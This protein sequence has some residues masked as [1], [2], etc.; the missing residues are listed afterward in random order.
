MEL[1]FLRQIEEYRKF[2][3][4]L[5]GKKGP[6]RLSG[7]IEAAKPY[8]LALLARDHPGPVVFIRSSTSVLFPFEQ[9][10]RF[11]A[12]M[13]ASSSSPAFPPQ[14]VLSLPPLMDAPYQEIPPSLK[15]VSARMRFFYS[16]LHT[17]PSLVIT[18]LQ[19]LLKPFP[20]R[21]NVP[22]LFITLALG[23]AAG[24]D[25]FLER[26]AEFGYMREDLV[27]AHGEYAWRGGIVDIFSPWAEFPCRIEFRGDEI[28]S[29][30]EFDPTSQRS[31]RKIDRLVI[32]SLHEFPASTDFFDEWEEQALQKAPGVFLR[33]IEQKVA[34]LKAGDIFPSFAYAAL[35]NTRHFAPFPQD[36]EEALFVVDDFDEVA[37][38]WENSREDFQRQFADLESQ[39]I[40]ALP[41]GEIFAPD[42]W[43]RIKTEAV[44]LNPL[45]AQPGD[46]GPSFHLPF[47]AVPRFNNKIPFFMDYLK[48]RREEGER[49][50]I[51]MSGEGVRRK[52]AV[53]LKQEG[54]P[55]D[56]TNAAPDAKTERG[57]KLTTAYEWT[58]GSAG[59]E[60][61]GGPGEGVL[62]EALS[63]AA[64]SSRQDAFPV[65]NTVQ[66]LTGDLARGFGFPPA[67]ILYFSERD[68][69]T[70]EKVLSRRKRLRP[71]SSHFQDLQ[72]GD[73]VV[74][75][76]YGIG[77][78]KGLVKME[79]EEQAR[80]F[81]QLFYKD[82]DKLFVPVEDLNLV[83]KYAG[84]GTTAPVL[85]KLGTP[86]W[87][88]TKARTKKAVEE[89]AKELLHLYAK[90]RAA[91]GHA[92]GASGTWNDD[93]EKTFEFDETEDQLNSIKE[94]MGD[95]ESPSPMDR[96]LVGD[97]GYGKTEVALRAAFKAVL[98]GMQVAVLCPTTVLASQHLKTF[99]RRLIFFPLRIEGLT[100]LQTAASRKKIIK[101]LKA[102]LVDII[103]GTHRLL[104]SDV[105]FKHLGLLV[106]DE[107]Q[108]FGV[109]HKERF[110]QM[111]ANIDVLTLTATPI[112]RTLNMSLSGLR[113]ISLIETPPVDRLSI[114]TVVIP[115][116]KDLITRAVKTE[117]ARD[118]QVYFI[119]NRI[120]DIETIAG[121]ISQWV[122]EAKVVFIHGRMRGPSLEKRMIDFIRGE[123]NVLV[124]TTII[125]NGIDIPRVN[126]LIV[127]RA[128]RFGLAQLYQL[129][130]R[131]G[132][133]ATQAVAYFLVPSVRGLTSL[134]RQRLKALKEFSDL[135]S[136]FRLAAKDLEIRG[137]G[138]FLGSRQHGFMEAVGFDYYMQL[139]DRSVRE[140][141][142]EE[143]EEA[144]SRLD[145]K[146]D[147]RIPED[148]LPQI[149][150]RLNLYKRISSA[151]SIDD[152]ERIRGEMKDRFGP[153]PAGAKNLLRYGIIKFLA[154]RLKIKALDR[155]GAKL[156]FDFYPDSGA[157]AGC[158]PAILKRYRGTLSPQGVMSLQLASRKEADLLDETIFILKELS[159]M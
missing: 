74:H 111:K 159:D 81:I 122:P 88:K 54:I 136:G 157:D 110:K 22:R 32:P 85:N 1:D 29:L 97:V 53:L 142:G 109:K 99:R 118:G 6:I 62:S 128:D 41:P 134:A 33:D 34:S 83:Q 36:L 131:V 50:I 24:R 103:I 28:A 151:E 57:G 154:Q 115:F 149:N 96:L 79:V 17:P 4:A 132:R 144:K 139:L 3:R 91:Q 150:L 87:E 61:S 31:R 152:I 25:R 55:Y 27:N 113:D 37:A 100:R 5:S 148:Y 73:Y 107:E 15:T 39:K 108:R 77:I 52:L 114:H 58:R 45:S 84:V 13:S 69:F 106:V 30:R 14:A 43:E 40:F 26:L 2:L 49:C 104:S 127:N 51:T 71:F 56:E 119:H 64:S 94:I 20:G 90:R 135:G 130:G 89:L 19:A 59:A 80:E 68:I 66:L 9:Q 70:A 12:R 46:T 65:D 158:L 92:F 23:E 117:L 155:V 38:D 82:D 102:G 145:L 93:L 86:Q 153:L 63:D 105:A 42:L 10:C 146:A 67:R 133:S 48:R 140:L 75:T 7:V 44:F 98:D 112:P 11:F 47:Q 16:L 78:F 124:S 120:D 21:E 95:M 35:L 141:K 72:A 138:N 137:A 156:V 143:V 101:D 18:N 129:R 125:E 60:S 126:T 147:I 76:D 121:K 8:V 116:S 123:Y